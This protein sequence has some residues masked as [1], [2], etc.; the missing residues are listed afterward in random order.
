MK[1][2][3]IIP[4]AGKG[5]RSGS[6][7][8]KQYMKFGGKELI[9]HTLE[10]FQKNLLV[11]GIIISS[12]STFFKQ[13]WEIKEKYKF[14]KVKQI[15]EGG[16]ERQDSVYNALV[17]LPAEDQD[18]IIVHDAARPLLPSGILTDAIK[19]AREKGNA[20][21]C[22]KVSDTLVKADEIVDYY[23]NREGIYYVQTPQIFKYIDL[24]NAMKNAYEENFYGTD[25]SM[26]IKR[27]NQD[28]YVVEGSLINFKVT[29]NSDIE[30]LKNLLK[31]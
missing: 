7:A 12:E 11:D 22:V 25:E 13:L 26:L 19:T 6:T 9:V 4:A 16:R 1:T 2:F 31:K 3:A 28:I 14:T 8:P 20:L 27:M 24:F 17:S 23:V 5:I 30:L 21:V 10:V 15:V 18:L 29:T